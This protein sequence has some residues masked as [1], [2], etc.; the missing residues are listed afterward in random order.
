MLISIVSLHQRNVK[1][2]KKLM[3]I[4]NFEEEKELNRL[5]LFKD[6][7]RTDAVYDNI[8]SHK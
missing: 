1:K 8:K 3:E 4:A 6:I 5:R 2:S 7:F